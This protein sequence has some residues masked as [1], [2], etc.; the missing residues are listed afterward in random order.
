MEN[1]TTGKHFVVTGFSLGHSLDLLAGL[2]EGDLGTGLIQTVSG[3]LAVDLMV[4][5]PL[6]VQYEVE[7][8]VY[9]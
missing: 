3:Q 4:S 1:D 2:L 9:S 7:K 5:G 8:M 6:A